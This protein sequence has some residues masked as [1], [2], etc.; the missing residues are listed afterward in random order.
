MWWITSTA[1][2]V[3]GRGVGSPGSANPA[4]LVVRVLLGAPVVL[5]VGVDDDEDGLDGRSILGSARSG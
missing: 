4:H 2:S 5:G 1:A 3:R